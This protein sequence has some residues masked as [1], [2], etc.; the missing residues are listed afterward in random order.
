MRTTL[1]QSAYNLG[2]GVTTFSFERMLGMLPRNTSVLA[3]SRFHVTEHLFL[4]KC[5]AANLWT[6]PMVVLVAALPSSPVQWQLSPLKPMLSFSTI[7]W[8]T[9]PPLLG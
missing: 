3:L 8:S 7:R 5:V 9:P 2:G 1:S 4:Y 6:S